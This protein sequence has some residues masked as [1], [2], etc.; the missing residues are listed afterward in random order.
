MYILFKPCLYK[1]KEP[2]AALMLLLCVAPG[3]GQDLSVQLPHGQSRT[4]V[5]I[6]LCLVLKTVLDGMESKPVYTEGQLPSMTAL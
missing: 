2:L 1:I 6:H 3:G 5:Y 4:V